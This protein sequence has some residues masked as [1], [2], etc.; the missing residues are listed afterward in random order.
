MMF[1]G[2]PLLSGKCVSDDSLL[3]IGDSL[4][5]HSDDSLLVID[6]SLLVMV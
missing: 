5:S 6:D 2:S 1:Q 4:F 3:V